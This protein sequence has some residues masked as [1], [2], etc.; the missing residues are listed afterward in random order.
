MPE[1][2]E[3]KDWGY[4]ETEQTPE[5]NSQESAETQQTPEAN[6]QESAELLWNCPLPASHSIHL[7]VA[8]EQCGV[9]DLTQLLLGFDGG[10]ALHDRRGDHLI[11]LHQLVAFLGQVLDEC[12]QAAFNLVTFKVRNSFWVL[13]FAA[14]VLRQQVGVQTDDVGGICLRKRQYFQ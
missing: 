6:S 7:Q 11:L 13:Q 9:D 1:K 14:K 12:Q 2:K 3:N 5:A 4:A 10:V 8:L